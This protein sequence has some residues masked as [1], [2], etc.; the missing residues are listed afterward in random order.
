MGAI[1]FSTDTAW[2]QIR[3]DQPFSA[4]PSEGL[5]GLQQTRNINHIYALNNG[6]ASVEM[7]GL[8][9]QES[10]T[11]ERHSLHLVN[12]PQWPLI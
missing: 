8:N 5:S 3:T 12:L 10:L 11:L 1:L 9:Y 7:A 2:G 4:L 6:S